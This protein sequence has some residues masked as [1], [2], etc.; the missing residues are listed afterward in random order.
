[1]WSSYAPDP[2]PGEDDA[3]DFEVLDHNPFINVKVER[4]DEGLT[5]TSRP[6][7]HGLSSRPAPKPRRPPPLATRIGPPRPQN[8]RC[9]P[10]G[11]QADPFAPDP[12]KPFQ[13]PGRSLKA[14]KRARQRANR[15]ARE[16]QAKIQAKRARHEA[17]RAR[18]ELAK[19]RSAP[20]QTMALIAQA[21]AEARRTAAMNMQARTLVIETASIV[22]RLAAVRL[23]EQAYEALVRQA[24]ANARKVQAKFTQI[25]VSQGPSSA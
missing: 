11:R 7:V 10:P 2:L 19:L 24:E 12:P 25:R 8:N 22:A 6:A 9:P 18:E 17:A 13:W 21:E 20:T 16:E 1:M 15:R 14:I 23:D 3:D 5:S 4:D